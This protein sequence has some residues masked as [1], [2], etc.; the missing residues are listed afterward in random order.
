MLSIE[1]V[2]YNNAMNSTQSEHDS[3]LSDTN[4]D[5]PKKGQGF[6]NGFGDFARF[7]CLVI[8]VVI[9]IRT[10]IAQPFIVS[11]ASM[12]PNFSSNDYLIVDELSYHFHT[13]RYGDVIIFHPPIDM[14][15]YYIKRIIGLPGDHVQVK[16]G[17]VTITNAAHP[18]GFVLDEPYVTADTLNEDK[19]A[20]V[21]PGNYFVMGDNRNRSS[22]S[23]T[24]G[25][26]PKNLMVGRAYLRLLPLSGI[27]YLPGAYNQ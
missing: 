4:P 9:F 15:T 18:N 19:T 20:D 25:L 27:S 11:G 26:L 3:I 17:V 22:D 13:P 1:L 10:V 21:T 24:W 2:Y 7:A 8:I 5:A 16:N 6:W 23:R 12:A 14:K